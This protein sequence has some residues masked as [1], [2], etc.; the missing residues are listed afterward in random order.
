MN[1]TL[2]QAGIWLAAGGIMVLFLKKR[3]SRRIERNR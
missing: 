1:E 3:R 2:M